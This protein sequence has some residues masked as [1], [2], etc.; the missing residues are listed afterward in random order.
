MVNFGESESKINLL[1]FINQ[2]KKAHKPVRH[3]LKNND[4][5]HYSSDVNPNLSNITDLK[6]FVKTY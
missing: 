3:Q 2:H 6:I 1:F 5:W 4:R